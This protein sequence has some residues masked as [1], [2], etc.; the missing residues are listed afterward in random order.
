MNLK[1][2]P[3]GKKL[4]YNTHM[5]MKKKLDETYLPDKE[6][7]KKRLVVGLSGGLNS[8]VTAYLLKIQKYD[9]VGVTV[10]T[11]WD[12]YKDDASKVLSC[13]MDQ[14][15]IDS[16]KEFCHQLGIPHSVIKASDEFKESVV[17]TWVAGKITGTKSN[18]CWNCHELR[19]TALY[20]K[21][22]EVEA[23]GLA[24]GHLA[25]LFRQETHHTVYVHTSNDEHFD[26]SGIL[27][28]LPH[29][30]LDKLML[31]LSDLQQKEINKLG[32]NFGLKF[33]DK[34]IKMHEC[35][36]SKAVSPD[37]LTQNVSLRYMKPGEVM[38]P[39]KNKVDDHTGITHYQFAEVYPLAHHRQT[40]PLLL[41]KYIFQEKKI[42][43]SRP[44]HFKRQKIFLNRCK[45]SEETPWIQPLK[46]V[47][48]ISETEFADCW[49]Y[50]KNIS[51]ALVEMDAPHQILEGDI[52]TILK[53]KGKNAKVYLTGMARYVHEEQPQQEEGK[54]RA[55]VDYSRDF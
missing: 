52:V 12:N 41:S 23:H 15:Q 13:H 47:V 38:D 39:E 35:F 11:G 18:P 44:E 1:N 33:I 29:E 30:I 20:Q 49:I 9:L 53:K 42:E 10:L 34:K 43:L 26:Q 17:E 16:I 28:R 21:M 5:D 3:T 32:D 7:R 4:A 50:P 40:D 2:F 54:E 22:L 8:F 55:K 24:T 37:Y 14:P 48:K 36:D 19:M 31:P 6:A 25:K 27:S 45:I 51:S 46:G